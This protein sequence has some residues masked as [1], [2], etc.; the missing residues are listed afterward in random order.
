MNDH[1]QYM[2]N[3]NGHYFRLEDVPG[4]GN[5]FYSSILK[6]RLLPIRHDDVYEL[7]RYL[8]TTACTSFMHD[9]NL[10]RIFHHF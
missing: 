9:L 4:D 8:M 7:R 3:V 2:V 10:Q 5:C 1:R 6:S